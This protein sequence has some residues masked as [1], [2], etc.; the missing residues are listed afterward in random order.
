V[1]RT[2]FAVSSLIV[3]AVAGGPAAASDPVEGRR[4]AQDLCSA[5]HLV[6]PQ[7]AGPVVD[8]VPAFAALARDRSMTDE[9]LRG[10]IVDPHPQMPRVQ[11]TATE[12]DAIVA[13]IR[14]LGPR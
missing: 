7:Q 1:T 13:Y 9:A 11:L 3:A 10:F 2:F 5:C 4:L 14:S 12:I 8:G 6:T